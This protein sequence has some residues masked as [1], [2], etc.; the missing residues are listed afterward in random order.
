MDVYG[1]QISSSSTLPPNQLSG[2]PNTNYGV[3]KF[4]RMNL[5][6][7]RWSICRNIIYHKNYHRNIKPDFNCRN[8][9]YA[10]IWN[11]VLALSR[12]CCYME[13]LPYRYRTILVPSKK[14]KILLGIVPIRKPSMLYMSYMLYIFSVISFLSQVSSTDSLSF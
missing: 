1:C 10:L 2:L 14:A 9:S 4:G 13:I 7:D 12:F 8:C 11:I 5:W 6:S 3:S